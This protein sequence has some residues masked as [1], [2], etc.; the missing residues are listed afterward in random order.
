MPIK[1]SDPVIKIFLGF[2]LFIKNLFA[3]DT[4][5]LGKLFIFNFLQTLQI[6]S[7]V[8]LF[9][10]LGIDIAITPLPWTPSKKTN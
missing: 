9:F 4:D 5:V 8:K 1:Y 6:S 7:E 3:S 10:S 2:I